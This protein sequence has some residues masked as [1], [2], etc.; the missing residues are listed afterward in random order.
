MRF[1]QSNHYFGPFRASFLDTLSQW[2]HTWFWLSISG[3]YGKKW[4]KIASW[5]CFSHALLA[6]VCPSNTSVT[7]YFFLVILNI[8]HRT[9]IYTRLY[10][11]MNSE[12]H[13]L[14]HTCT[15]L[16][17]NI[18]LRVVFPGEDT[19]TWLSGNSKMPIGVFIP[20]KLVFKDYFQPNTPLVQMAA[21]PV[22]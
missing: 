18:Q 9:K 17:K 3:N 1:P 12:V 13:H 11:H 5:E 22:I 19:N 16:G 14:V 7:G 8:E 21:L 20:N 2:K 6:T 15:W 4:P 10:F